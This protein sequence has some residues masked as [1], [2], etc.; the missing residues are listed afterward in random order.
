VH[1]PGRSNW[2]TQNPTVA[3]AQMFD[4]YGRVR[5]TNIT[6]SKTTQLGPQP[7]DLWNHSKLPQPSCRNSNCAGSCRPHARMHAIL[8]PLRILASLPHTNILAAV[9]QF[10]TLYFYQDHLVSLCT[11][12]CHTVMGHAHEDGSSGPRGTHMPHVG[13]PQATAPCPRLHV[14]AQM[15]LG[16]FYFV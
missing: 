7:G 6:T 10:V 9:V 11:S 5:S 8:S 16:A 4:A 15:F 14:P 3:L 12:G 2:T 1:T 13:D